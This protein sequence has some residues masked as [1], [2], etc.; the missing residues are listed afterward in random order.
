MPKATLVAGD[1]FRFEVAVEGKS[2]GNTLG[3][4]TLK[5]AIVEVK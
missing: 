1:N 4:A 5:S 2:E 3:S